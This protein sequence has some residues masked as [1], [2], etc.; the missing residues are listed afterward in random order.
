MR[1]DSELDDDLA[2]RSDLLL[3][4]AGAQA[5]PW[6]KASGLAV[7]ERG[8]IR[9]DGQLRAIA[10]PQVYAVGD[11]AAWPRPLPKAG[12]FAVRMGPILSLNLRAALGEG[13]AQRYRPQRRYL[14][15]LATADGR[16]IGTWAGLWFSGRWVWRWKDW[17]DRSFLARY[18]A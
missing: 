4:A 10:H 6:Q 9:I 2:R 12:V 8:F 13:R 11:C 18:T 7:N 5:H 14:M 16:A 1:L 17:I 3:W 15:L